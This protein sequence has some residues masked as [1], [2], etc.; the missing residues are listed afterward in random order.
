MP[1]VDIFRDTIVAAHSKPLRRHA[2]AP[3]RRRLPRTLRHGP[4][5]ALGGSMA[6]R[7][8]R[9]LFRGPLEHGA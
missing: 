2:P 8:L 9:H 3:D 4:I 5:G 1:I 7:W 6:A